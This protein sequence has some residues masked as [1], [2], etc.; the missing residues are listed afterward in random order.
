VRRLSYVLL[1]CLINICCAGCAGFLYYPT[2]NVYVD[3]DKLEVKPEQCQ[4]ET[5]N[6][7]IGCWY[8]HATTK[9]KAVIAL[10]HGNAQNRSSHFAALY[11]VLKEGY[12]L[13]VFDYPGYADSTGSPNPKNTVASGVEAL[14]FLK[15][16]H[17]DL[18][19]IVYGQSLGGAI[20]LRTVID[21]K[22]EIV[23]AMVVAD[24][25]FLSYRQVARKMLAKHWFSWPL[26]PLAYLTLSDRYAPDDHI[27]D[28]PHVPLV[29]IDSEED[30][31]VPYELGQQLFAQ[32]P[33]PK[34][35]WQLTKSPHISGFEGP[36]GP[37]LRKKFLD[38]LDKTL[39]LR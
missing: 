23:P 29:V 36:E 4:F 25:T 35:F 17:P 3:V 10:F 11:W 1:I 5:K 37:A 30:H 26:Q 19:I 7:K 24:S 31:I 33:E 34:E 9:P 13:F 20:A 14:R 18:P 2:K 38:K 27:K 6:E 16:H 39:V 22:N 15:T 28:F 21:A 32:A 12:D 8:F